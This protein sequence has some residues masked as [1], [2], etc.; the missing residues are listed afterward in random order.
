MNAMKPLLLVMAIVGFVATTTPAAPKSDRAELSAAAI[1]AAVRQAEEKAAR[2]YILGL[3]KHV[4]KWF[5]T[6]QHQPSKPGEPWGLFTFSADSKIPYCIVSTAIAWAA[7]SPR[8]G[9]EKMPGYHPKA[10]AEMAAWLQ[11]FQDPKTHQFIDPLHE[12][13][14]PN[15]DDPVVRYSFREAVTK[16]AVVLLKRC[17]AKP[18]H[19]YTPG[20]NEEGK[21][22]P[23]HYLKFIKS[24]D[25]DKHAWGIGSH[26]ALQTV[27]VFEMV[28]Q[29]RDDLIPTLIEGT[30][31]ILSQQ[32]PRTGMW[33]VDKAGIEQ[34][35]GGALK[36]IGRFQGHMG[37]VSPHM[38][39][40]ADSLIAN[41]RSGAFY[42]TDGSP[43]VP[44]NV[45]EM[46]NA[47][48]EASDYRRNELREVLVGQIHELK[49]YSRADGSFSETWGG[50]NAV[51]WC[52]SV[53]SPKASKPRA[54]IVGTQL[55]MDTLIR[56]YDRAG[57][58]GGTWEK[59]KSWRAAVKE[60]NN[61]Y[62]IS[63]DANGKVAVTLRKPEK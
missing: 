27:R 21:F 14:V 20:A 18:L 46:V 61:K 52:Q 8:E 39:K 43:C 57:W 35:I 28:N 29:G 24:G 37:L 33:G 40:L 25:W 51:G 4:R 15:I 38:D 10:K 54:D 16:Y 3:P 42:V 34:Q 19:P 2:K 26:A 32:N 30:E 22:D 50:T 45:A 9:I 62:E 41:Y 36:V 53:V 60:A 63:C 44:R 48:L 31:F 11:K 58:P 1:S 17:E 56:I 13:C 55:V 5:A 49:R 7:L 59:A 12:N 6:V 47:C 23:E